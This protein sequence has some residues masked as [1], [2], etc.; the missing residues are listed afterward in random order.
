MELHWCWQ[1]DEVVALFDEDEWEP[2]RERL[3]QGL[4]RE[5]KARKTAGAVDLTEAYVDAL[6][7]HEL[8]TGARPD[9]PRTMRHHRLAAFGPPCPRCD[10]L[11]R[12]PDAELCTECGAARKE[13]S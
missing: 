1:C 6:Q 4:R 12:T 13:G 9:D 7:L 11:L 5:R 2:L 10:L 3:D 8:L